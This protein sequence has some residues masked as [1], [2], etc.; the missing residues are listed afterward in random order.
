MTSR[1]R[2]CSVP[3]LLAVLFLFAMFTGLP[4]AEASRTRLSNDVTVITKPSSWNRIVAVAVAVEAGSKYDPQGLGGLADLTSQLL[5]QGTE[6]RTAM[7]LAELADRHGI[8]M[9]SY[10]IHDFSGFHVACIDEHLDTALEITAEMLTRPALDEGRFLRVQEEIL[11]G[12]ESKNEDADARNSLQLFEAMFGD[13]P[14]ARPIQGTIKSVKKITPGH[15]RKFYG[16]RYAAENTVITIVGNFDEDR[17]LESLER[18]LS[19]Y[20]ERGGGQLELP[21]PR[22]RSSEVSEIYMDVSEPRISFGYLGPTADH[23]DYAAMRVAASFLCG[24]ERSLASTLAELDGHKEPL[25]CEAYLYTLAQT[26]ALVVDC[27]GSDVE[28]TMAAV[29]DAVDRLRSEPVDDLELEAA[30]NSVRGTIAVRGQTNLARALRLATDYLT[31]GR[32]DAMGTFLEQV[33]RV[34]RDDVL[35]AAREYLVSPAVAIVRPG[36]SAGD[37]GPIRRGI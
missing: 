33:A 31:T 28:T 23:K 5:L 6:D 29:N 21:E 37:E 12:I 22:R 26:S 7:E 2:R 16:S 13:H 10:T 24:G 27:G 3:S 25:S 1:S 35:R 17:A 4:A 34:S 18:L 8:A 9:D 32:V 14:Y 20:P 15:V 36:R 11:D 30:R 19:S